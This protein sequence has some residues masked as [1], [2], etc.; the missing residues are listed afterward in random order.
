MI[1]I[2]LAGWGDHDLIYAPGLRQQEKLKTYSRYFSIVEVDSSYY[3]ILK[4]ETYARWVAET[5]PRFS[6]VIKA[7]QGMTGQNRVTYSEDDMATLFARFKQSISPVLQANRCKAVLLQYPPWFDCTREHV[8]ELRK[9]RR[10]MGEIPVALEF[11][12]QS[13]FAEG[14]RDKTL[15][16][17]KSEQ[18]IHSICDEPQVYP[19]SV[20]TVLEPTDERLTIIRFHG[21]NAAGWTSGGAPNWREVRYL[22]RYSHEELLEWKANLEALAG[23]TGEIG[24]IFNNNSGGDAAAN[25]LQLMELLGAES[26]PLP[27]KQTDLFGD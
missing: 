14:M 22:Y 15:S 12:H 7:F 24:V 26:K 23:R 10:R 19:G 16:F 5:S 25:A 27:P 1:S 4:E 13:W 20:P 9:A 21:R 11:R 18:W 3:A 8:A 2:G 6:F 17:M